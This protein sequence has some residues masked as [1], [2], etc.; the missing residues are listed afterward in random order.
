M[1]TVS[2]GPVIVGI[3]THLDTHTAAMITPT[4]ELVAVDTF[5]T[6][7]AGYIALETW[8]TTCGEV[9]AVG[10]EGTGS[11]GAELTR[12]LTA[13]GF[14]VVEVNQPHRHT[15]QRRGK[16]D[17]IDAEA[18]ARKVLSGE[19]AGQAK[20]TTGIVETIRLFTLQRDGAVK[21]RTAAL[22]QFH[23]VMVTAPA[24]LRAEIEA[25]GTSTKTRARHC[26]DLTVDSVDSAD[27]A[28]AARSVLHGLAT[29]I[30]TL[31]IEINGLDQRL[32]RL[33]RLAAPSTTAQL[34]VST[35]TAAALLIA[36]GENIDRFQNEAA[37]AHLCGTAPVPV[38]SGRTNRHR[39]NRGGHRQANRALYIIALVRLRQCDTTKTYAQARAARGD[40][41]RG[42]IRCLKRHIARNLYRTLQADLATL[43][44]RLDTT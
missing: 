27:A 7:I 43:P 1:M 23:S 32:G 18:A 24:G 10:V 34:G 14:R 38:S 28:D 30:Q 42:T 15:R 35:H 8:M 25:A 37:F 6:T 9:A 41:K 36:A 3:D 29:R 4:G 44:T 21:A 11:Y 33:V 31:T 19:A 5:D 13:A 12:R 16:T 17:A 20:D 2:T 40:T 26:L 39:L 22:C